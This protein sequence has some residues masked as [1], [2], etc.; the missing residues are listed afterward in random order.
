[1][2]IIPFVIEYSKMFAVEN[3]KRNSQS[4]H[5]NAMCCHAYEYI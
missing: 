4:A 3:E 2:K 5:P 1:M